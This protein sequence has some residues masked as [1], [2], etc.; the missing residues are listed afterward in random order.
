MMGGAAP[1]SYRTKS[2]LMPGLDVTSARSYDSPAL[3][4]PN[5]SL[6]HLSALLR[7]KARSVLPKLIK[8]Q[9]SRRN[10]LNW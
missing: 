7:E 9:G 6:F 8:I 10:G 1:G 2:V 4:L 3:D 5:P